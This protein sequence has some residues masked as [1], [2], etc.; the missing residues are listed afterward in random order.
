MLLE[1][2]GIHSLDTPLNAIYRDFGGTQLHNGPKS[3]MSRLNSSIVLASKT[4][5]EYPSR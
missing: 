1:A 2:S 5:P 3:F 4:L